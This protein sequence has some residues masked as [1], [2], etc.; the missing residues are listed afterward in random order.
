M[1]R[2]FPP[3]RSRQT[4][5]A[6]VVVLWM[7]SLL[8]IMA[9]SFSLSTQ[10]NTGLVNN[11]K[12]RARGL[13]LADAG[14]HY[15]L[16]MLSQPDPIKRWRSDGTSYKVAL[17]GGVV[18]VTLFDESGKIDINSASE[19]T[20]R[21]VLGK[22]MGGDEMA[23]LSLLDKIID[24]RDSDN[25][26][27]VNGAEEKDYQTEGKAY[28]PQNKNF[29]V[30]EELQMVLGMTPALYKKLEPLLTI[31]SG[32]DGINPQK[33]SGEALRL[34][35]G[36][37]EKAVADFLNLRRTSPPNTPAPPLNVPPGGVRAIGG[38]DST[39]TIFAQS[40]T[41]EGSGAGLKVVARR[42]FSRSNGAPFAFLSWKQQILGSEQT[43]PTEPATPR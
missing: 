30:L 35:F 32:Q 23:A 24:W 20:L 36:M 15:A 27:R 39:Y 18:G 38:G 34:L 21:T 19:Q 37:D 13:A 28:V 14:V 25:L 11:A 9:G 42:Q 29:Q 3:Y 43:I 16:I 41:E 33:A 12:E 4:G 5:M 26:K 1:M 10:R 22:L 2:R 17:P 40:R 8:T 6:M 7:V 31:Y